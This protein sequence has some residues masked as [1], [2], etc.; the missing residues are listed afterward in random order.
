MNARA[1]TPNHLTSPM[2]RRCGLHGTGESGLEAVPRSL[3]NMQLALEHFVEARARPALTGDQSSWPA[4]Y[5]QAARSIV[6]WYWVAP[7]LESAIL[8]VESSI[9]SMPKLRCMVPKTTAVRTAAPDA[10]ASN[11][12]RPP[13]SP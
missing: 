7:D 6:P 2:P 1:T 13:S 9:V 4:G 12:L 3:R 8:T 5:F 11:R 10:V